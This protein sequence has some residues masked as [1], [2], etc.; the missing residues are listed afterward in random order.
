MKRSGGPQQNTNAARRAAEQLHE[1]TNLLA[2]SQQQLAS[3]KVDSLMREADRLTGQERA[4]AD[5]IDKLAKADHQADPNQ[6]DL[7]D[8]MIRRQEL[9]RLAEE[10]ELAVGSPVSCTTSTWSIPTC[11][12][13]SSTSRRSESCISPARG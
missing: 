8:M 7:A 5:R 9:D 2:G 12:P 3:N 13:T 10:R 11:A 4:Q 1:A 6:T